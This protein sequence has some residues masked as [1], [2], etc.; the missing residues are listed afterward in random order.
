MAPF[1]KCKVAPPLHHHRYISDS[2]PYCPYRRCFS[3]QSGTGNNDK[4][5]KESDE[6]E[7]QQ[8]V[9]TSDESND[10]T[11]KDFVI[12][13]AQTGGRKLAIVYTCKVCETRSIKQFTENSYNKGVVLV[14]CPG[15]KNL[16]LIADRLGIFEEGGDWDIEKA[17]AKVGENVKIVNNDSVLEFSVEDLVGQDALEKLSQDDKNDDDGGKKS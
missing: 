12:P 11:S 14:R 13:G 4:K 8:Q 3:S 15:C 1:E 2:S 5:T 6:K 9:L 10:A 7:E 17:M 16:H